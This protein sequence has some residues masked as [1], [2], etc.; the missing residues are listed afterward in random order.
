VSHNA[1]DGR[2]PRGRDMALTIRIGPD[3]TTYFHDLTIDLLPVARALAP[4]DIDLARRAA[5]AEGR[6]AP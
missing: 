6:M 4:D 3:G 2:D 1:G 5:A